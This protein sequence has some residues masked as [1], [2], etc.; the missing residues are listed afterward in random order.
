M[1]GDGVESVQPMA[2][3]ARLGRQ[4]P[5]ERLAGEYARRRGESV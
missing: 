5:F 1:R 3:N 2:R 4:N